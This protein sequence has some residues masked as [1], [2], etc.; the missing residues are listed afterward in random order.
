MTK[1][2]YRALKI[3]RSMA[4][5]LAA[6]YR[7]ADS[8]F[9][10]SADERTQKGKFFLTR[11][12]AGGR[13]VRIA[14]PFIAR[15]RYGKPELGQ[16]YEPDPLDVPEKSAAPWTPARSRNLR[17]LIRRDLRARRVRNLNRPSAR[18]RGGRQ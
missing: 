7:V 5:A 4:A 12:I 10:A 13:T 14:V 15:H 18:S 8:D 17:R 2:E 1:T 9:E 3:P 11:K 16:I 6:G